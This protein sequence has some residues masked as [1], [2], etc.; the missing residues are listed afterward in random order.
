MTF[1]DSRKVAA[2]YARGFR[3]GA[4]WTH[5]F[6]PQK[7]GGLVVTGQGGM[8]SRL[9]DI[10]VVEIT[11]DGNLKYTQWKT[12]N[13]GLGNSFEIGWGYWKSY[14]WMKWEAMDVSRH[15]VH[16]PLVKDRP[17]VPPPYPDG[18]VSGPCVCG[19]WPGGTCF[20]CPTLR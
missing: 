16:N 14:Y 10:A 4:G 7:E 15:V 1:W 9:V 3:N 5:E 6:E 19:S 20:R 11:E 12:K 8:V 2:A 13:G 18:N 17:V